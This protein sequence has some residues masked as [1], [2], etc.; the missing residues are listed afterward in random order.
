MSSDS[1]RP[2]VTGA[3]ARWG[4]LLL[5]PRAAV[6]ALPH[7]LGRRDGAVFLL[8]FAVGAHLLP[9]GD[10]L[11]DFL[12]MASVAAL[13]ALL[14][15]LTVLIPWLVATLAVEAILGPLRAHRAALCM[16]PMLLLLV[17]AR[18]LAGLG[19]SVPVPKYSLEIAGALLAAGLAAYVRPAVPVIDEPGPSAS[20]PRR[21]AAVALG[22]AVLALPLASAARD[23]LDL[24][25]HWQNLAP[26]A[27]GEPVPDFVA[28]TIDGATFTTADLRGRAHLLVFFTSWCGVCQGEMPKYAALHGERPDLAVVGVNCDREGDQAAIARRYRDDNKLPFPIVL[29]R[30]GLA[31]ASRLSVYPH[32][33]LIDAEGQIRWVHQGRAIGGTLDSAIAAATAPMSTP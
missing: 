17:L 8:L 24:A 9:L 4:G 15:G 29:D 21:P 31:R 12:A 11:A 32:L 7:G 5:G 13:P 20:P 33:V 14:S 1:P 30:G 16:L 6:A 10:A 26:V 25:A 18:L 22:L 28:D 23:A 3:L 19:L 2:A 27:V